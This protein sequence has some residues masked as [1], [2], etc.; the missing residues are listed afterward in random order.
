MRVGN[1]PHR[2]G[3]TIVEVLVTLCVFSAGLLPIIVLFHRSQVTTAKAKNLLIAE[4]IGRT[5]I[6]ELRALGIDGIERFHKGN[7]LR[8][9]DGQEYPLMHA[10]RE[11]K[12]LMVPTDANATAF[13]RDYAR[14]STRV[15]LAATPALPTDP[16]QRPVAYQVLVTVIWNEGTEKP[17]EIKFGTIVRRWGTGS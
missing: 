2:P 7:P 1:R 3:F 10:D 12:G 11:V 6:D 8:G 13:P 14:F 16:D 9:A 15:E 5:T 17:H 4:T